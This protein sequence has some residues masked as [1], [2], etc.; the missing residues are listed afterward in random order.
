MDEADRRSL[1]CRLITACGELDVEMVRLLLE[2]GAN[3][4]A[5]EDGLISVAAVLRCDGYWQRL[6]DSDDRDYGEDG[7]VPQG[8]CQ[9]RRRQPHDCA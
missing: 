1:D 4:S 3:A 6:W 9:E 8:V 7:D 5:A 2:A